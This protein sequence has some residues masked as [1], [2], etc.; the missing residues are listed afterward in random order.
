[1]RY[2]LF[3]NPSMGSVLVFFFFQSLKEGDK[4]AETGSLSLIKIAA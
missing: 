1:M 2:K 3:S 4:K